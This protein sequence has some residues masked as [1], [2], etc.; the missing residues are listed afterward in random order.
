MYAQCKQERSHFE[1]KNANKNGSVVEN[2]LSFNPG[3]T[4]I[5]VN[6]NAQGPVYVSVKFFY[7]NN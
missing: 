5:H 4:D 7:Q 6:M 3:K 1:A 2:Q